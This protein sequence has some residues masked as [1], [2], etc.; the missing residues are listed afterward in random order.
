MFFLEP[1][2]DYSRRLEQ[3]GKAIDNLKDQKTLARVV[4]SGAREQARRQRKVLAKRG[5]AFTD[6]SGVLRRSRKVVTLRRRRGR[7]LL[8]LKTD[9]VI[10][11]EAYRAPLKKSVRRAEPK[12]LGDFSD[13]ALSQLRKEAA[14][15]PAARAA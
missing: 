10:Y 6:R 2:L 9:Y 5:Y 1:D 13:G 8:R 7:A 4:A 3:L 15:Q 12:L 11:V 14:K